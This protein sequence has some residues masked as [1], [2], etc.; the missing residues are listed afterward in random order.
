MHFRVYLRQKYHM[1]MCAWS[2]SAGKS[3]HSC[4]QGPPRASRHRWDTPGIK[5]SSFKMWAPLWSGCTVNFLPLGVHLEHD[6][7]CSVRSSHPDQGSGSCS[8]GRWRCSDSAPSW[9]KQDVS[10]GSS[11]QS[12]RLNWAKLRHK[13]RN[14]TSILTLNPE[15]S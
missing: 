15:I 6:G 7:R 10:G 3:L 4:I 2:S 13:C 11:N 9:G 8:T 5:D 12:E 14:C 1:R